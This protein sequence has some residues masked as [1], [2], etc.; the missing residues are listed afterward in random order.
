MKYE[1]VEVNSERWFDLTPLL[2]EEF[3]DIKGYE[4]LYQVSNYGR[5]K[6][7]IRC[8]GH[9]I[10]PR[11]M[12]VLYSRK[13]YLTVHLFDKYLSCH[14]AVAQAFIPNPDNKPQINHIDLNKQNNKV[15]N[16]EWCTNKENQKHSWQNGSRNVQKMIEATS[17][18]TIQYDLKMNKIATFKSSS[19]ASRI[20]GISQTGISQCCRTNGTIR[21][22]IFRYEI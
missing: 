13:G 2:N 8:N 4:G 10:V 19:E 3:R 9:P 7:F 12:K 22:Y 15:N 14:R 5:Y 6:S 21:G 18:K 20:T 1:N 16:L 17:K 11:I